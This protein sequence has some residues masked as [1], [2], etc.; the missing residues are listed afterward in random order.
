M[1]AN[2]LLDT[3]LTALAALAAAGAWAALLARRAAA[4]ARLRPSPAGAGAYRTLA[5]PPVP[6]PPPPALVRAGALAAMTH[7]LYT[8]LANAHFAAATLA[9]DAFRRHPEAVHAT[10]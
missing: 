8:L 4:S 3:A 7:G 2:T 6:N 5:G 10:V 9:T 1:P